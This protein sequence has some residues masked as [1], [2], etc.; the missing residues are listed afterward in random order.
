MEDIITRSPL[1][2]QHAILAKSKSVY[3]VINILDAYQ[4]LSCFNNLQQSDDGCAGRGTSTTRASDMSS[5]AGLA[6]PL[7]VEL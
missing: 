7:H 4:A 6:W 2:G 3:E 5:H 1:A